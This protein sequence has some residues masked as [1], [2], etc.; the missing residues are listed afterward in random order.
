[1]N[2]ATR[3]RLNILEALKT[4]LLES[5]DYITSVIERVISGTAS[6]QLELM[7]WDRILGRVKEQV[8]VEHAFDPDSTRAALREKLSRLIQ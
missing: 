4:G 2:A 7:I 8:R 3:E 6:P 5:E 1:M